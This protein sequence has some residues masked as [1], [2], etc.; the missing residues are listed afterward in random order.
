MRERNTVVSA[1]VLLSPIKIVKL[2]HGAITSHLSI[3]PHF[4]SN[5]NKSYELEKEKEKF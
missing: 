3:N 1:T 2:F 5:K 4:D